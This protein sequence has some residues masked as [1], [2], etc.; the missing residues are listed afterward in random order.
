M[1][2][3]ALGLA[4]LMPGTPHTVDGHAMPLATWYHLIPADGSVEYVVITN[5]GVYE[6]DPFGQVRDFFGCLHERPTVESLAD[7][8]HHIGGGYALAEVVIR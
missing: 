6:C 1:S 4:S 7:A 8:L 2:A 5:C 3:T